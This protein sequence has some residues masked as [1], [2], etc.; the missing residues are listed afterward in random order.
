VGLKHGVP[1]SHAGMVVEANRREAISDVGHKLGQPHDDV[2]YHEKDERFTV[3]LS[4]TSSRAYILINIASSLTTE[5]RYLSTQHPND[6]F[7][8]VLPRVQEVEYD[9]THHGNS[10]FIRTNDSAKTF[11]LVEAPVKDPSKKNWKEILAGR[12]RPES[13]LHGHAERRHRGR[14]LR[15]RHRDAVGLDPPERHRVRQRAAAGRRRSEHLH[16][17]LQLH[18][19]PVAVEQVAAGSAL[20]PMPGGVVR[21][22]VA[23]GDRVAAGQVLVVLEA[24]KMEHA[25]HAGAAGTVTEVDVAEGDQVETGRILAVVEADA[26]PAAA[27]PGDAIGAGAT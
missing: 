16:R 22:H 13:E 11:R 24:M 5:V 23:V 4:K 3:E 12:H 6:V 8:V 25:V 10:F 14:R 7:Q 18:R 20:A 2:V 27:T 19:H 1:V 17:H 21:V 9:L 26:T 15:Q